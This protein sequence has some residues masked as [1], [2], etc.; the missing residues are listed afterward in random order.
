MKK[1]FI[2]DKGVYLL[3]QDNC[4]DLHNNYHFHQC[5]IIPN[6]AT[7]I[8]IWLRLDKEWVQDNQPKEVVINFKNVSFFVISDNIFNDRIVQIQEI[9]YKDPD[10]KDLD[11]LNNESFFLEDSHI[12][13]RFENDEFMRIHAEYAEVKEA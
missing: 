2:V 4:Y 13:F 12:I 8:L 5:T 1:N 10:D 6:K 3:N 11:W 7:I 9:G